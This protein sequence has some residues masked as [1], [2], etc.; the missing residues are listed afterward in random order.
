MHRHGDWIETYTGRKF[1]PLDPDP[2]D[3][4]LRDIAHALARICRFGGHCWEFYSVA[5]HAL[6]CEAMAEALGLSPRLRLLVLLHD[7][8]EAYLGDWPRPIKRSIPGLH[9]YE[10][11][12]QDAVWTGLGVEPPTGEELETVRRID[13]WA[14]HAEARVLMPYRGWAEAREPGPLD[15][16]LPLKLAPDKAENLFLHR[17]RCL[18]RSLQARVE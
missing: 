1:W 15:V 7:A 13:D 10:A 11:R 16:A 5:Q 6:H 8:A 4:D 14:L 9:E 3:I 17:A 12:I 2:A 18:Q